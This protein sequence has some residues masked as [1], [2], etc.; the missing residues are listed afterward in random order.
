M[1]E[2][3]NIEAS[4]LRRSN[5]IASQVKTSYKSFSGI[6]GFYAFGGLLAM[7]LTQPTVAFYHGCAS[8]N[9]AIHQ[10]NI[11]N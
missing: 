5:S 6:S 9:A 4:G 2:M 1:P 10:F 7:S 8:V 3:V 11:I